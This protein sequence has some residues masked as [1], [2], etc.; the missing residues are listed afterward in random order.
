MIDLFVKIIFSIIALMTLPCL[1]TEGRL[2]FAL[3][4]VG[5][6]AVAGRDI[7]YVAYAYRPNRTY[8][9]LAIERR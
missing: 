4:G 9:R 8:W 2:T 1:V 5:V 6:F 7:R 3:A